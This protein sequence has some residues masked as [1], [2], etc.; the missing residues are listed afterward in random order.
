MYLHMLIEDPIVTAICADQAHHCAVLTEG[1]TIV[2]LDSAFQRQVLLLKPI[3]SN[4]M[5]FFDAAVFNAKTGTI[6]VTRLLPRH[7][8]VVLQ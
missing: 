4:G 6:E 5:T 3:R 8:L 7:E 1:E 2:Y